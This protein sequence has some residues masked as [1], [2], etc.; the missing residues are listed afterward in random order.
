MSGLGAGLAGMSL[1]KKIAVGGAVFV[2][3]LLALA[4]TLR[5][6][7]K[8]EQRRENQLQTQ[9]SQQ[10]RLRN[11]EEVINAV[12]NAQRPVT[13]NELERVRDKYDRTRR[14]VGQ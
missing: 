13:R 12:Q 8:A 2:F 4:I 9:G 14:Q 11:N 3:L 10:E 1:L 6:C 7:D 5:S